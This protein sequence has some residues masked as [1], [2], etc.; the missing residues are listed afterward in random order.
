MG[1]VH[2]KKM[3]K[4]LNY[5]FK[6]YESYFQEL[7]IQS[8]IGEIPTSVHE[9]TVDFLTTAGQKLEKWLLYQS[10]IIQRKSASEPKYT[11]LYQ[12][13]LVEIK[14]L[15]MLATK[16]APPIMEKTKETKKEVNPFEGVEAFREGFKKLKV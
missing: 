12:G 10:W 15:L 6:K 13:M 9:P 7:F 5:L 2:I 11:M 8:L 14:L 16:K 3:K 1:Y 4:I